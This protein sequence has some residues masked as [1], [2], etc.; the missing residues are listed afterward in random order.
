[1]SSPRRTQEDY[2]VDRRD[3]QVQQCAQLTRT[4]CPFGFNRYRSIP[5]FALII[6]ALPPLHP[7][8][9]V[10]DDSEEA[11]PDPIPNSEVKLLRA[12]GTAGDTRWES[13]SSRTPHHNTPGSSP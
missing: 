4:N 3:V 5:S 2:L 12:D 1:M 8:R 11:L 10:R 13:R 9:F 6:S 7:F